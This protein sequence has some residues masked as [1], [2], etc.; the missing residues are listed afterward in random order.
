MLWGTF[1]RRSRWKARCRAGTLSGSSSHLRLSLKLLY[2]TVHL[3]PLGVRVTV[4][5]S[6][7][8][9]PALP[10]AHGAGG[11][12]LVPAAPPGRFLASNTRTFA[13]IFVGVP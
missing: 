13:Q 8:L 10:S 2:L 12:C 4:D 7:S 5:G 11:G 1:P 3:A 9:P 6:T